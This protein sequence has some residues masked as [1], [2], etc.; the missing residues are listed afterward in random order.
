MRAV[1]QTKKRKR[2]DKIVAL[3]AQTHIITNDDAQKL[4]QVSDSTATRYLK[5]LVKTGRLKLSG[6]RKHERY[7]PL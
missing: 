7:E 1:V 4:L 5:E 6:K 3:A 2:L